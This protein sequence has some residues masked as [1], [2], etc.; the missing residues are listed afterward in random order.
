MNRTDRHWRSYRMSRSVEEWVGTSDDTALPPRVRIRVFEAHGGRCAI[1]TREI[2]PADQW[3]CDHRIALINGGEHREQNLQPVCC[4]CD[5]V[6]K[7][8]AD[9]ALKAKI[10]RVKARYL[11][12]RCAKSPMSGSR[13]SGW[14]RKLSGEVVPRRV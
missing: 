14:K 10:D 3:V 6:V 2:G 8:P 13:A 9:I 11:G 12:V 7:T 5:R 1:C 4:W